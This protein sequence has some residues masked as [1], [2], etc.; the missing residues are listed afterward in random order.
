MEELVRNFCNNLYKFIQ[1]VMLL[2]HQN[3]IWMS[4]ALRFSSMNFCFLDVNE[5]I[6]AFLAD[7]F[8]IRN[9]NLVVDQKDQPSL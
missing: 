8:I 2:A 5:A 7:Q 6:G 9:K 3:A 4:P 1:S